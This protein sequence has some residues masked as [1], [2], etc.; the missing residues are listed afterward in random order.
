MQFENLLFYYYIIGIV[1][2]FKINKI[3]NNKY[4]MSFL[5]KLMNENQKNSFYKVMLYLNNK[6]QYLTYELNI[7]MQ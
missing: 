6:L 3:I 5:S 4:T 7:P 2:Y 1:F